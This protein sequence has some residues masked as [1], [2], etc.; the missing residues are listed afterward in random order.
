M[1]D[2]KNLNLNTLVVLDTLLNEQNVSRAAEKLKLTQPT[3]SNTLKQLRIIFDDDLLIRGP[4]N[5]MIL[6]YRAKKLIR[7]VTEAIN[8]IQDVFVDI[9]PFDPTETEYNFKLGLSDLS[10]LSVL[11]QLMNKI[12]KYS[13]KISIFVEHLNNLESYDEF[14]KNKLDIA[15]GYFRSQSDLLEKEELY[16]SDLVC[17]ASK[18]HPDFQSDSLSMKT[19]MKFQ[20]IGVCYREDLWDRINDTVFEKTGVKRN[21]VLQVP[22][23]LVALAMLKETRFVCISVRRIAE[24]YQNIFGIRIRELPFEFPGLTYNLYWKKSDNNNPAHIWMRSLIIS[25]FV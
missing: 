15:I 17:I 22:H 23:F 16:A 20:H 19:F 18:S 21:I 7:P 1:L 9:T 10:S 24:K 8:K 5:R 6:S 2:L 11:P 13:D 12:N 25:L 4:G 14:L 3:I